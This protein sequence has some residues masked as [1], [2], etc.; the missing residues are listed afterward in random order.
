MA[1][2]F[3][4]FETNTDDFG[5]GKLVRR[6][7]TVAFARPQEGP[8]RTLLCGAAIY[9]C[10]TSEDREFRYGDMQARLRTTA[11]NRLAKCPFSIV[12]HEDVDLANR[13]EI[14]QALKT[15]YSAYEAGTKRHWIVRGK[16]ATATGKE[17]NPNRS[18]A[19]STQSDI[20]VESASTSTNKA[21]ERQALRRAIA[22]KI[23]AIGRAAATIVV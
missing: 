23:A 20:T 3:V 4:T 6:F 5:N 19:S 2:T 12:L 9:R 13:R 1:Q 7:I 17:F 18:A 21:A 14:K 16:R 15:L 22:D 11:A 10:D 8:S